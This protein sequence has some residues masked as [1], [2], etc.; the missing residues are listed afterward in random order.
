M[1][2]PDL[3]YRLYERRLAQ[4]LDASRLPGH[5][6]VVLDGNRRW[7]KA[8]G[9]PT[10]RGHQ[11]GADKILE[12][13]GWSAEI[14][15]PMVTLYMLS[16]DNLNRDASEL[17]SLVAI[18]SDTLKRLEEGEING[19]PIKVQ[20]VGSTEILPAS[21]SE[22]IRHLTRR[23][24]QHNESG[25]HVNVAVGYG[26]RQEIVDGVKELLI[27][28]EEQGQTPGDVA[29][30][31]SIEEISNRLYTR[32]LPDPDL[33]IRTSG[34]QRLSGFLMWQSAY[35]EF[36]FCEALWPDFRRVDFLRALRDY[37]SRQRR[38]GS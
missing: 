10:A 29:E 13:L 6:G 25:M 12:F 24:A 18:I 34:E 3:F 1:D 35:A 31:L 23:G 33:V 9:E 14:G 8:A 15:I 36:Y 30:K 5:I 22:Q 19:R 2:Y 16:T 38:Y 21:L 32:G 27:E 17:R 20:P 11:A 37:A 28:A 7:A 26:G 4:G